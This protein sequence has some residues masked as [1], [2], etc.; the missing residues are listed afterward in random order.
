MPYLTDSL[1]TK[2]R[3]HFVQTTKREK[4]ATIR[5]TE[6]IRSTFIDH[7]QHPNLTAT[8]SYPGRVNGSTDVG[9]YSFFILVTIA[10]IRAS[11]ALPK[12]S[13]TNS[14]R[15]VTLCY[16]F[17]M[18][19]HSHRIQH[20]S[21]NSSIHS[22]IRAIRPPVRPALLLNN[23]LMIF[24]LVENLFDVGSVFNLGLKLQLLFVLLFLFRMI[25]CF[26]MT[27]NT[28]GCHQN[29]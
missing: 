6:K 11:S 2:H 24:F 14:S 1:A 8:L 20:L 28:L 22:Q 25:F 10:T 13:R 7:N 26:Q 18:V 17:L 16:I 19:I 9:I 5:S 4:N 15:I 29:I 12:S 21:L 27:D 3:Q 23:I